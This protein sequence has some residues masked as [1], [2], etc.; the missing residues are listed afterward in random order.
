MT[1]PDQLCTLPIKDVEF[2]SFLENF[3]PG[4]L[5]FFL[6][7]ISLHESLQS[8]WLDASLSRTFKINQC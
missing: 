3:N 1:I 6:T 8:Y 2:Q 4:L 5:D 7:A